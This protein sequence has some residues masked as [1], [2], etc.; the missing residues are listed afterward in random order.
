MIIELIQTHGGEGMGRKGYE[1]DKYILEALNQAKT[2]M[3]G[4]ELL[5]YVR[6]HAAGEP[7]YPKKTLDEALIKLLENEDIKIVGYKP[8]DDVREKKQA[9]KS[10]PSYLIHQND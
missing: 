9:F 8:E 3:S 2:R 6:K 4:K 10:A 1:Y 7:K 5:T